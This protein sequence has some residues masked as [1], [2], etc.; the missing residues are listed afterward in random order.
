MRS[1]KSS[2]SLLR[3]VNLAAKLADLQELHYQNTLVLH[4][5]VELLMEKGLFT[6][7]DLIK[8]AQAMD[9]E[10]NQQLTQLSRSSGVSHL[11]S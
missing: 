7:D 2:L 1:S 4:S 6:N 5:I 8:K 10:L 9:T 3:E 11:P